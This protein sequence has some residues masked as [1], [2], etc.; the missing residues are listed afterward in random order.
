M[1]YA[2]QT[3]IEITAPPETVWDVLT[4]LDEYRD[5][6][7]FIISATGNVE[8]GER[9]INR[10]QQPGSRAM[11]IKPTVTEVETGRTF[12]W[13]GVLG[14]PGV[15]D[16]RHRFELE[17]TVTGTRLVQSEQFRGI[18]VRFMRKMIDTS[19]RQAFEQMN[20]ALKERAE[21]Q[22]GDAS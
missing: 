21:A 15:F 8:V 13:L 22:S 10:M 4:N 19:T 7:P 16:G 5:W 18:L 12:E 9:L 17:E 2:L 20:S 3:D 6:N 11:T 14:I 1:N